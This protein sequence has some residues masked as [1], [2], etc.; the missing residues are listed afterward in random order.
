M[1]GMAVRNIGRMTETTASPL[2]D[3][4]AHEPRVMARA[5]YFMG[6]RIPQI[7]EH[8]GLNKFTLYDARKSEGWDDWDFIRRI[9]DTTAY[10]Y[11]QLLMKPKKSNAE[12]KELDQLLRAMERTA[13]IKRYQETGVEGDL[14]PK[15]RNAGEPKGGSPKRNFLAP[16]HLETLRESFRDELFDYQAA[17]YQQHD[18]RIRNLLKSRQIGA[19]WY[20]AREALMRAID[21]GDPSIFMSASKAQAQVFRGYII[22]WV[23]EATGVELSGGLDSPL[24]VRTDAGQTELMFLGTNART[25]QSYHGHVYMDEYFWIP[26]FETFNKV[27]SGMAMHKR[28]TK[29]YISTPS[30]VTHEAYPF[31]TGEH[32]NQGRAERERIALDVSNKALAG[33][34]LDP[35]GQWRQVVTI[36]DAIAGGC[37]LFDLEE[38]RREYSPEAY[39]Q[40]LMCQFIDD[41]SSVF[42]LSLLQPC[43]VDSWDEWEDF[44]RLMIRPFGDRPVWIGYD[45]SPSQDASSVVVVA[46]KQGDRPARVLEKAS[47]RKL[48]YHAQAEQIHKLTKKYNVQHIGIDKTGSGEGVFQMVRQFFPRAQALH[49]GIEVKNRLVQRLLGL[50]HRH[51]IQWDSGDT[52]LAAAL[53]AIRRAA[54]ASGANITY[55][56]GRDRSGHADLAWALM[57]ALE[58]MP[59]DGRESRQR[60]TMEIS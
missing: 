46:P 26:G 50:V 8:L 57:N 4:H 19:T 29:T 58:P 12:F 25:A 49:Y 2:T 31:W 16:E 51:E 34:R 39:A 28:W 14:N 9:E 21:D 15:R 41:E 45:P 60:S 40:L 52:D 10:R 5:L 11:H 27:A 56:A 37:D 55:Q 38:L 59:L 13:R 17:W 30:A 53:M 44:N 6:W 3:A 36:E 33:G 20:F 42:P 47:W 18:Q 22:Q 43:G 32:F 24:T 48:P 1:Q 35:D 23:R 7:A 54:T